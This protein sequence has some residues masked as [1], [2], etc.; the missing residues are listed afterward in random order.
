MSKAL[1][2]YI[3]GRIQMM[4][5]IGL[6]KK[7]WK[8]PYSRYYNNWQKENPHT[9]WFNDFF[10]LSQHIK[11]AHLSFISDELKKSLNQAILHTL[12]YDYYHLWILKIITIVYLILFETV[13]CRI[14]S[15][16]VQCA[17]WIIISTKTTNA[18]FSLIFCNSIILNV[19]NENNTLPN[20]IMTFIFRVK[21]PLIIINTLII[22]SNSILLSCVVLRS[23][24]G[25]TY[26]FRVPILPFCSPFS[27]CT[28]AT[29]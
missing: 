20:S 23:N 4:K 6:C 3:Y 11:T 29:V 18:H 25:R 10:N 28:S 14:S 2:R 12:L 13:K 15:Q 5:A 1:C 22:I 24:V 8:S 7:S 16:H 27:E 19:D 21:H 26:H 9:V 17:I